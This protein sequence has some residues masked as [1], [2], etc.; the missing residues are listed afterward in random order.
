[1]TEHFKKRIEN[2][3]SE[4]ERINFEIQKLEKSK[5]KL[6]WNKAVFKVELEIYYRYMIGKKAKCIT[7]NGTNIYECNIVLINDDFKPMPKFRNDKGKK[8]NVIDFDWL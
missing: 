5:S 1:M 3:Y 8:I 6:Y 2:F 7:E 4:L